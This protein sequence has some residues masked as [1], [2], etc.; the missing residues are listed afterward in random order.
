MIQYKIDVMA[1]LKQAGYNPAR[2][3][4]EKIMGQRSLQQIREGVVVSWGVINTLCR[5]LDCQPGDIVE[6]VDSQEGTG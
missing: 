4:T 5:L 3:R 2:I 6:Y 1:A